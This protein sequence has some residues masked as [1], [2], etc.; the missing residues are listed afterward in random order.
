MSSKTYDET[1]AKVAVDRWHRLGVR[2]IG[3][4][5]TKATNVEHEK[6]CANE[7]R[8]YGLIERDVF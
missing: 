2:W 8:K 5:Q 7:F 4:G 1:A 3:D 6:K